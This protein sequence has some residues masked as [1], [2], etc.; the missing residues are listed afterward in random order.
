MEVSGKA[1]QK[2]KSEI[3]EISKEFVRQTREKSA[4]RQAKDCVKK[5]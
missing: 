4:Y 1:L 5:H 2:R 3:L